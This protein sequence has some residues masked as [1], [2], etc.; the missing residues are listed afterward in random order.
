M[1]QLWCGFLRNLLLRGVFVLTVAVLIIIKRVDLLISCLAIPCRHCQS[2]WEHF[3]VIKDLDCLQV[4]LVIRS[5]ATCLWWTLE[6][7]SAVT[8]NSSSHGLQVCKDLFVKT[9]G[10]TSYTDMV[11]SWV[12]WELQHFKLILLLACHRIL[13]QATTIQQW[14]WWVV[15][16]TPPLPYIMLSFIVRT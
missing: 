10:W 13:Q 1:S 8:P 15:T 11:A 12:R 4:P 7:C 6:V 16:K 3:E 2:L 5:S 14:H 9:W